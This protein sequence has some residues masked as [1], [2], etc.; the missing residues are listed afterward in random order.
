MLKRLFTH[1]GFDKPAISIQIVQLQCHLICRITGIG[2][3]AFYAQRE[4]PLAEAYQ[5]ASEVMVSNMLKQDAV[6]GINA[7]VEKRMPE[8]QD[9]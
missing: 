8:W 4:L 2:K 1:F 7:F 5:Y 6:E 3:Q 9:K